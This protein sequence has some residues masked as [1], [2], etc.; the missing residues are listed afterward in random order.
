[1]KNSFLFFICWLFF[2]CSVDNE[3][4]ISTSVN[5]SQY[6]VLDSLY[7]LSRNKN[8]S[9][10]NRVDALDIAIE[11]AKEKKIDSL[12][13]KYASY[14]TAIFSNDNNLQKA[15][16]YTK[17]LLSISNKKKDTFYISKAYSKYGLYYQK[18]HQYDSAFYYYNKSKTLSEL[19]KDSINSAKSVYEMAKIRK[20]YGDFYGAE[21]LAV[22]GL[23][24]IDNSNNSLKYKLYMILGISSNNQNDFISANTWYNKALVLAKRAI[25]SANVYNSK[26]VRSLK[27]DNFEEAKK[28]FSMSLN[29][30]KGKKS[31]YQKLILKTQ[32]NL[33]FARGMLGDK[34]AVQDILVLRN[35]IKRIN[36][37]KG[38]FASNIHLTK[39]LIQ[40]KK[41]NE[42]L[43]YLDEADRISD[44]LNSADAKIEALGLRIDTEQ[45]DVEHVKKYKHLKDSI[46]SAK[47]SLKNTFDKI[48]FETFEK[49]RENL[50]LKQEK[51][52]Q[53]LVIEKNKRLL[54]FLGIGLLIFLTLFLVRWIGVLKRKI[55]TKELQEAFQKGFLNYLQNKYDLNL[56]EL[57]LW[58][59]IAEGLN[60]KQQAEALFRSENTI[61]T[62]KRKGLYPKLLKVEKSEAAFTQSKA[63]VLYKNELKLYQDLGST[64]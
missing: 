58:Q 21:T 1:M 53:Q 56:D 62:R 25:D 52:E 43:L 60:Q 39:L 8:S 13:L 14:K 16:K 18:E 17:E 22:E 11:K 50:L 12:L 54:L 55:K 38:Q 46:D 32:D 7:K 36:D 37:L 5:G 20:T 51:A 63:I 45:I 44:I 61:K 34:S 6:Q 19:I 59:K 30:L 31:S 4:V 48:E 9:I 26:G 40:Q 42:A 35:K 28:Y 23:R 33:A 3:T 24:L 64:S 27:N 49:E 2:G 15:K 29:L 10:L 41:N 47:I 57:E